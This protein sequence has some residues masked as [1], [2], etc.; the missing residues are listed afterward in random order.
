[1]GTPFDIF[2]GTNCPGQHWACYRSQKENEAAC[3]KD[4]TQRMVDL[5]TPSTLDETL[6]AVQAKKTG[7]HCPY[8]RLRQKPLDK[9]EWLVD[10]EIHNGAHFP[11]CVFTNNARARSAERAAERAN[12]KGHGA[13]GKSMRS[14]KGIGKSKAKNEFGERPPPDQCVLGDT[15]SC[16]SWDPWVQPSQGQW[17]AVA[18]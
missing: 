6:E 8:L 14:A 7:V 9:N 5:F 3:D 1:M 13:K 4:L 15:P 17:A 12:R 16:H 18:G 2:E 11:L 10:G